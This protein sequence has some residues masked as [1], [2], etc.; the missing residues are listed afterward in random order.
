M[1]TRFCATPCT[2][3]REAINKDPERSDVSA[4]QTVVLFLEESIKFILLKKFAVK[5]RIEK[6]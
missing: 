1:G 6:Y 2:C 5:P 4:S 3:L